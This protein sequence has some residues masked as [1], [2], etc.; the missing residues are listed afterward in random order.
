VRTVRRNGWMIG[1]AMLSLVLTVQPFRDSDVWWHLAM[2]HYIVAHG[3]PAVEPFSFLH[4]ANPWVGQQ[5]LYEVGLARVVDL[6]GAALASLVMGVVA[7]P[8]LLI[9]VLSIPPHRRP[10]GPWMAAALILSA[11]VAAQ[12]VGVR[13]QVIS[14][15]GAAVVLYVVMRWRSGSIPACSAARVICFSF[16]NRCHR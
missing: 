6:G 15:F 2:G 8:A 5:W 13:G 7:S 16:L 10:A 11:L 9:A 12:L 3:I 14:L 1:A 4:A